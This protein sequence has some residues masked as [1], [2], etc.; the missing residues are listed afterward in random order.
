MIK[1][2]YKKKY[3]LNYNGSLQGTVVQLCL[4]G[5]LNFCLTRCPTENGGKFKAFYQPPFEI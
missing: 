5:V 4:P 2:T 3:S 1:Q